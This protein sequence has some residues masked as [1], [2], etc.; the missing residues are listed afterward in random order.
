MD[1]EYVNHVTFLGDVKILIDTI[2]TVLK[3]EG[4]NSENSATVEEFMGGEHEETEV[5]VD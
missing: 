1:V 4:V 2:K 3:R 5:V